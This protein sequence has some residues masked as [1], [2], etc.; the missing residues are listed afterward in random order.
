MDVLCRRRMRR[1]DGG[2]PFGGVALRDQP[3][4]RDFHRVR[5]A[6][7]KGAVGVGALHRLDDQ[8]QRLRRG[9]VRQVVAFEDVEHFNKHDAAGRR[10]R[11][12]DDVIAAI[13]AAHRR[14]LDDAIGLEIV[15]GH[16]AAGGLHRSGDLL[17]NLAFV[18]CLRTV[19]R[20]GEQR[21]GKV[22]LYEPVARRERA[23]VAFEKN[24]RRRRP[25]RQ[26]GPVD[27]Q[28]IRGVVGHCDAVARQRDRRHDQIGQREFS[29]A[30]FLLGVGEPGDGSGNADGERGL[31]RFLRIGIALRVEEGPA[32]DRRRRDFAIIDRRILAA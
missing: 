23:A 22:G 6:E 5:I 12:R 26:A 19:L 13:G 1:I 20:D 16:D 17:R 18:K 32:V 31:A 30:V 7:K 11:H 25:A 4:H 8:E 24:L 28:R 21:V 27:G 9:L 10:R 15:G 2:P 3:R 14:A 29:R